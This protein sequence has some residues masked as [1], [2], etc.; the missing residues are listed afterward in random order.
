M[1][2]IMIATALTIFTSVAFLS[3]PSKSQGLKIFT[4][5]ACRVFNDNGDLIQL[6]SD[7]VAGSNECY[8]NPCYPVMAP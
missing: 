8:S 1:K 4:H 6:G 7:C 5:Y 2:R 3:Y